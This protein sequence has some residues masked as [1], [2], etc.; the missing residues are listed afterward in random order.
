MDNRHVSTHQPYAQLCD[1]INLMIAWR[2][3]VE[4]GGEV[5]SDYSVL[6]EYAQ[7]L[8]NNLYDLAARLAEERYRAPLLTGFSPKLTNGQSRDFKTRLLEDWIVQ[9]AARSALEE[10]FEP[11]FLDCSFGF[12]PWR[13]AQM[14]VHRVL[15]HR[16][17]GDFYATLSGVGT[18]FVGFNQD[19]VLRAIATRVR[20]T[21]MLN[22]IRM[23]LSC[24]SLRYSAAFRTET[25][26]LANAVTQLSQ[27]AP[28]PL[29]EMITELT[30]GQEYHNG[31]R[32]PEHHS[33][34]ANG[35]NMSWAGNRTEMY[36]DR[37]QVA[38]GNTDTHNHFLKSLVAQFGRDALLVTLTSLLTAKSLGVAPRTLLKPKQLA[39]TATAMLATAA[40]PQVSHLLREKF[41]ANNRHEAA[42]PTSPIASL[43]LNIT[44]HNFDLG[45]TSAGLHLV[46]Y[47]DSFAI[48]SHSEQKAHSASQ[49]AAQTLRHMR[50]PFDSRTTR[51]KRFDQGVEFLGYRFHESLIAA[52]P[53]INEQALIKELLHQATEFLRNTPER[54]SPEA[55]EFSA[56]AKKQVTSGLRKLKSFF[57][58]SHG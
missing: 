18:D 20:D 53:I 46:R 1:P 7:N 55:A 6:A 43:L 21:R 5:F 22:L 47:G 51:V 57:K 44:M 15:E 12:R 17:L 27:N 48:T 36:D 10:L 9:E 31:Y 28:E 42:L 16:Q 25:T 8:E 29:R 45:L 4:T 14:A 33:P 19:A 54:L 40:Y 52:T 50:L 41:G 38:A 23:W 3:L 58:G 37:Q 32:S 13:D 35:N 34:L 39:M 11:E 30:N 56:R 2:H 26:Q 49:T 24:G